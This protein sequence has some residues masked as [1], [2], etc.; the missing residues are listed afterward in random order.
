[1]TGL[2]PGPH[3][4]FDG[5]A[6]ADDLR[7]AADVVVVGSGAGGAMAAEVLA[8]AGLEVVMV[9]EGGY[10]RSA[11]FTLLE[12]DAYQELY[13]ES[14]SRKT[15]DKAISVLQGRTVGG[16]T[17]VNWTT[18]FRTPAQTLGHWAEVWNVAGLDPGDLAPWFA[19]VEQRLGIEPWD[20]APNTNNAV[21]A[22]GAQRLGWRHGII[23]R[24]VR[25]C[26]DLGYC[27]L[28]CP[29]DAKQ[30]MLLT[31]VP[32]ALAAGATLLTRVRAE[33][34][35]QRRG[36]V[37][38]L[39]CRA[40]EPR[41]ILPNGHRAIITA[42]HVVAAGGAIGSPGLL[43]R[44][45]LPDPHHRLGKRTFLHLVNVSSA[46]M[47]EPVRAFEGAPQSIY[48]DQF[49]W[50]DGADGKVGYKLEVPPMHPLLGATVFRLHGLLHAE[51]MARFADTQ[52]VIALM[53]DGFHADEPGGTVRLRDDGSPELDYR[54]NGRL[55]DGL[56]RAYLSMAELQFAA[57]A[58]SVLPH[59]TEAQPYSSWTEA[60][61]AIAG[62][63]MAPH[64]AGL[65]SAH[66]MGGCAMGQ[67]PKTAV[68]DSSGRHHQV[69]G[70][71]VIDGSLFPTSLGVN[72][73]LT[74]YALA[75]K[76][77]TELAQDLGGR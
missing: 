14:A 2:L 23:S 47:P 67:D 38:G 17:T 75:S 28:G 73:Q 13:Q 34:V 9:E 5:S 40:L 68:V 76:L 74:I 33:R 26:R 10:N 54:L 19:A 62:L 7:L 48:S 45:A 50:P 24:N 77:A 39:E 22:R 46:L 25:G 55:A 59:H 16:S 32:G 51:K 21:L 56:K 52:A 8:R 53:R 66:V 61:R 41:G 36:R 49:L 43:L 70:L 63:T 29:V 71:S 37:H 11:D 15:A 20:F 65:F 27:G 18:S 3:N 64:H 57:G 6:L 1:M 42:R 72:P 12:A 30:S 4:V 58:E 44:S 69:Q 31:A 35:L 60:R